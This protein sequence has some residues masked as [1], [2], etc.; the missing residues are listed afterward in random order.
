VQVV[1]EPLSGLNL[2]NAQT[3][4]TI[5]QG[6][7]VEETPDNN[8]K[9]TASGSPH[10]EQVGL[11]GSL[12]DGL[13]LLDGS[14]FVLCEGGVARGDVVD[15]DRINVE[16]KFDK[17]AGHEGGGEVGGEVVVKEELATH[18]VEGNVVGGPGEEEETGRVVETVAS[19]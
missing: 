12:T 18:D 9:N 5:S 2:L 1:V 15:V 14:L 10:A 7:K 8:S 16:D 4:L 11:D 3:R 17:G 19:T 6:S 13:V